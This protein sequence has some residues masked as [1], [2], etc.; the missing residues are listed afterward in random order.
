MRTPLQRSCPA[1]AATLDGMAVNRRPKMVGGLA[2]QLAAPMDFEATETVGL[3]RAGLHTVRAGFS[4][5]QQGMPRPSPMAPVGYK[6]ALLRNSRPR[7]S[8]L[9][10]ARRTTIATALVCPPRQIG[11]VHPASISR[12]IIT[13]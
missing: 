13:V 9:I 5:G 6:I 10:C 12:C 1:H 2:N 8:S 3:K 4:D 11:V 7:R